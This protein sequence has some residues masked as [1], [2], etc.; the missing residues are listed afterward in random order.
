MLLK[1]VSGIEKIKN[2]IDNIS[3]KNKIKTGYILL[4]LSIFLL[5]CNIFY[6]FSKI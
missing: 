5:I 4:I 1:M 2:K 6:L 3:Y